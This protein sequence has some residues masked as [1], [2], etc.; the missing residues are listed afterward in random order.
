MQFQTKNC[1]ILRGIFR[2]AAFRRN[3]VHEFCGGE[4]SLFM[5][6]E[7]T[8]NAVSKAKEE[9]ALPCGIVALIAVASFIVGLIIGILCVSGSRKA[10]KEQRGA[11]AAY[12]ADCIDFGDDNDEDDEDFEYSF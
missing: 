12:D 7:F 8:E 5:I 2:T 9:V 11:R 6:R 10:K 1:I 3:T 4:R